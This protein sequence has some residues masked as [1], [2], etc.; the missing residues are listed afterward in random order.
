MKKTKNELI[1]L[2]VEKGNRDLITAKILFNESGF[3]D[4]IC[5]HAQQA[6][7]KI[8]KAYLIHFNREYPKT[9]DLE[10]LIEIMLDLDPDLKN[11]KE[12][13][14]MLSS[15]AVSIRYPDFDIP[16]QE[17]TEKA[18]KFSEKMFKYISQK[19]EEK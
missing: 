9:H 7:E 4:I 14:A 15:Y 8:L 12:N 19:L 1:S 13:A 16:T 17:D 10:I 11:W 3:K 6:C 2:W 18:V 5:F